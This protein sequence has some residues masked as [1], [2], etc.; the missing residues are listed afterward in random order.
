MGDELIHLRIQNGIATLHFN[1]PDKRNALSDEVRDQLVTALETVAA[2]KQAR[3]LVLTGNGDAFCAGGDVA[4]MR[5]RLDVPPG[6]V[7]FSGWKR[8]QHTHYAQSLLHDLPIPTIAAVNGAAFGLGA[9]IALA[10]DFIVVSSKATFSWG[11]IKRGL[12]PDGGALYLLPRRV[13]LPRAKELV[14]SGRT[15][16]A[17]ESLRLGIADRMSSPEALLSDAQLWA[18]QL[19]EGSPVALALSK[20]II[21]KSFEQTLEGTFAE[22]SQAQAICYTSSEHR[23]SVTAFLAKSAPDKK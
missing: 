19:A 20:A 10:C 21:N 16:D 5:K 9:D 8:Q 3:A 12:I 1:R 2:E 15:V 22:G 7:A 4:A 23:D 14:F 13:G 18:A 11:Y 6:E 17:A